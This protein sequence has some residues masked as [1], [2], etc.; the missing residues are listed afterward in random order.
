M[1]VSHRKEKK[2]LTL[3]VRLECRGTIL[4]HCSLDLLSSGDSPT[5]A[6]QVAKTVVEMGLHHVTQAGLKLLGSSDHLPRPPKI[7]SDLAGPQA[8][9]IG[10][11]GTADTVTSCLIG[12]TYRIMQQ[13]EFRSCSLGWSAVA[14]SRL[15]TT[16]A[17]QVQS[18][19]HNVVQAGLKHLTSSVTPASACQSTGITGMSYCIGPI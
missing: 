16:S 17:S 12:A 9:N 10:S 8:S 5:T 3:L 14:Q 6:S 11:H 18:G 1:H 13:A 7:S 15:T 19:F 4:A 2:G